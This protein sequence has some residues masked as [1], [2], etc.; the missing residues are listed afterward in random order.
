VGFEGYFF[1]KP[2]ILFAKSDFHHIAL[3]VGDIGAPRAFDRVQSHTPDYA[4][5][6]FWFLQVRAINAGR[7]EAKKKIRD[8]LRNHGWPV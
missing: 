1:G 7:P 6:L 2:L 4:A 3:N 8:V 5:Y